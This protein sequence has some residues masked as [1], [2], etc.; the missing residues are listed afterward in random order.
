MPRRFR[1]GMIAATSVWLPPDCRRR[2]P[3]R[4]PGGSSADFNEPSA[5]PRATRPRA[6]RLTSRGSCAAC[7]GPVSTSSRAPRPLPRP[8]ARSR[9]SAS[10]RPPAGYAIWRDPSH[11]QRSPTHHGGDR[12]TGVVICLRRSGNHAPSAARH[13]ED[14]ATLGSALRSRGRRSLRRQVTRNIQVPPV[15]GRAGPDR[16]P[17]RGGR[18]SRVPGSL[19]NGPFVGAPDVSVGT[20]SG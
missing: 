14:E 8:L 15:L 17:V 10:R 7:A 9:G 1:T 2:A 16:G 12:S 5:S 19:I 4:R 18:Q 13:S 3:R 11:R 20:V 6:P